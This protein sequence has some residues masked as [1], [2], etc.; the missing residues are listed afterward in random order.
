MQNSYHILIDQID[1]LRV[2]RAD[3]DEEKGQLLEQIGGKGIVDST[4]SRHGGDHQNRSLPIGGA[5][6]DRGGQGRLGEAHFLR[7]GPQAAMRFDEDQGLEGREA[8]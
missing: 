7:D 6:T 5:R 8:H 1:A 3:T 2:L 4:F